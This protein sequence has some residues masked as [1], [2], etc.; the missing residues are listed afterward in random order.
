[1]AERFMGIELNPKNI[2]VAI[3]S[4]LAPISRSG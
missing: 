3:A 4:W 2:M 1:M